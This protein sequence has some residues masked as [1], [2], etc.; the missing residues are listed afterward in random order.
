MEYGAWSVSSDGKIVTLK[1]GKHG[2]YLAVAHYLQ[3]ICDV[4]FYSPFEREYLK[5]E[6][7]SKFRTISGKSAFYL[8]E[9]HSIYG[10]DNG[11]FAVLRGLNNDGYEPV[12]KRSGFGRIFGRPYNIHTFHNYIPTAKYFN[13]HPEWFAEVGGKRDNTKSAQLCLSNTEMRKEVLKNLRAYI[14]RDIAD[15]KKNKADAP[16]IYDI[17]QNDHQRFCRC[18]NCN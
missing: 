16:W 10:R 11:E 5:K 1:G 4:I 15:A 13:S 18:K 8:N 7:P 14:V 6:L 17:S 3:D 2:I 12:S 9:I